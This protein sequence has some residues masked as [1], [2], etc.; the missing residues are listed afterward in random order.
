[1]KKIVFLVLL[2]FGL[3]PV[4]A[5]YLLIPMDQTQKNH[6]KAY[7][8]A[9]WVV[10]NGAEV[11]WLLNYEGGS[12]M[13]KYDKL[14]E[15]EC[16]IRGVSYQ[17]I[18]DA[19]S[20]AIL[21][22][23]ADPE[24][25]MDEVKLFKAPRIAV[26]SPKNKQPWDDAVTLALQYA[27]IPYDVIYDEEV[28]NGVLP[29]YDWLH[30]HH[31]DFTGQYGK[32]WAAYHNTSWYKEDVRVNEEMAAKLGFQKVS[33]MKLA[34]VK[35]IRE[36]VAGGGYLFSMCSAPDS[37]DVALAA[38]GTDIC[39]SMFDHDPADPAAQSK[40][41]YD[42][43]F[44]FRNFKLVTN[45]YEYE[46]SSI[47]VSE[48]RKVSP[49]NDYF[50][51]FEFSAKWD[52]VPSMLCQDHE[53]LIHGFRGQTTAFRSEYIKPDVIIM[54]ETKSLGEARYIHGDFGK[55][56]WTFYGGHDPEDYEHRVGDPPTDLNLHP[57]SP[58]YRL[59]LNNVL[60]PAAKKKKQKT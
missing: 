21:T 26:Y 52:P 43:C 14:I 4:R 16:V 41:N 11:S 55:G 49:Q 56:T 48:S 50:T 46:I 35:K 51:L 53:Q 12:F 33:Q 30:M 39:E 19:Q 2:L 22:E 9:Y 23:I 60:F 59:I 34:V 6:L 13:C 28:L 58:G 24:V 15:N 54:G 45:P 32:F 42:N 18:A 25:N 17:V 29:M 47:D 37:Y 3:I 27:E 20:T 7:G 5:A 10:K 36:F 1:M 57:N 44:A 31:E 38:D 40:L 8:I